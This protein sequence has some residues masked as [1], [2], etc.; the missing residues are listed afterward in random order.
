M[1]MIA[2]SPSEPWRPVRYFA[3]RLL[4]ESFFALALPPF[5][6]VSASVLEATSAGVVNTNLTAALQ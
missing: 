2:L 1:I 5:M 4:G 6:L 3:A